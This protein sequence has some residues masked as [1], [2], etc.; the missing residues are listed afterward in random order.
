M[1]VDV[2]VRGSVAKILGLLDQGLKEES[3]FRSPFCFA[4]NAEFVRKVRTLSREACDSDAEGGPLTQTRSVPTEIGEEVKDRVIGDIANFEFQKPLPLCVENLALL[5]ADDPCFRIDNTSGVNDADLDADV[6]RSSD[7]PISL[8]RSEDAPMLIQRGVDTALDQSHEW[9]PFSQESWQALKAVV[10][11]DCE[12]LRAVLTIP[13]LLSTDLSENHTKI[14]NAVFPYRQ[15]KGTDGISVEA[16]SVEQNP[17]MFQIIC[18]ATRDICLERAAGAADVLSIQNIE[19]GPRRED[20][21]LRRLF[22]NG[23]RTSPGTDGAA[24]GEAMG[25]RRGLGREEEDCCD[26]RNSTFILRAGMRPIIANDN[27]TISRSRSWGEFHT[28]LELSLRHKNLFPRRRYLIDERHISGEN[29]KSGILSGVDD[30]EDDSSPLALLFFS[31]LTSSWQSFGLAS[32]S[33]HKNTTSLALPTETDLPWT[34]GCLGEDY[35]EIL[36]F[37][38]DSELRDVAV[39]EPGFHFRGLVNLGNTCYMNSALQCLNRVRP[40]T[41]YFL[42]NAY[43]HDLSPR[44]RF[45]SQGALAVAYNCLMRHLNSSSRSLARHQ[46]EVLEDHKD[47]MKGLKDMTENDNIGESVE[48]ADLKD[49]LARQRES[50]LGYRQQDAQEFLSVLLDSLHEDLKRPPEEGGREGRDQDGG[51]A[52]EQS[53]ADKAWTIFCEKNDSRLKDLFYG[54]FRSMVECLSCGARS[55][56]FDPFLFLSLPLPT[57]ESFVISIALFPLLT[58]IIPHSLSVVSNPFDPSL[59]ITAAAHTPALTGD[60]HTHTHTDPNDHEELFLASAS[61]SYSFRILVCIDRHLI[62]QAT[63]VSELLDRLLQCR[64]SQIFKE[65]LTLL[66]RFH[67]EAAE[68]LGTTNSSELPN[69]PCNLLYRFLCDSPTLSRAVNGSSEDPTSMSLFQ[70]CTSLGEMAFS[71]S[72]HSLLQAATPLTQPQPLTPTLTLSPME[73]GDREF[74]SLGCFLFNAPL[75]VPSSVSPPQSRPQTSSSPEEK[76]RTTPLSVPAGSLPKSLLVSLAVPSSFV[77]STSLSPVDRLIHSNSDVKNLTLF[78]FVQYQSFGKRRAP[79]ESPAKQNPPDPPHPRLTGPKLEAL[80]QWCALAA[81]EKFHSVREVD[82]ALLPFS[83]DFE[84]RLE[85]TARLAHHP[86]S[87]TRTPPFRCSLQSLVQD[88]LREPLRLV[89]LTQ[90]RPEPQAEGESRREDGIEDW[91]ETRSVC[92]Y[93]SFRLLDHALVRESFAEETTENI[94]SPKCTNFESSLVKALE[95]GAGW[96]LNTRIAEVFDPHFGDLRIFPPSSANANAKNLRICSDRIH[97]D[98][99][100]TLWATAASE[101]N[102]SQGAEANSQPWTSSVF[103]R[104]KIAGFT[105]E[106]AFE[107]RDNGG[108]ES[109]LEGSQARGEE[110]GDLLLWLSGSFPLTTFEALPSHALSFL[111]LPPDPPPKTLPRYLSKHDPKGSSSGS[112]HKADPRSDPSSDSSSEMKVNELGNHRRRAIRKGALLR[113]A[114]LLQGRIHSPLIAQCSAGPLRL[115]TLLENFTQEELLCGENA[116]F[117]EKCKMLQAAR[118]RIAI[119]R[120]PPFLIVHLG[121]FSNFG[122]RAKINTPVAFVTDKPTDLTPF[123]AEEARA[124]AQAH[125][126]T[127]APNQAQTQ[128]Q[129]QAQNQLQRDSRTALRPEDHKLDDR[130]PGLGLGQ[131]QSQS[132]SRRGCFEQRSSRNGGGYNPALLKQCD[133]HAAAAEPPKQRLKTEDSSTHTHT[134]SHTP[135]FKQ[136]GHVAAY[137]VIAFVNHTG[138]LNFG[139]YFAHVK[140]ESGNWCCLNDTLVSCLGRSPSDKDLRSESAYLLFLQREG[141]KGLEGLDAHHSPSSKPP[142]SDPPLSDHQWS[143]LHLRDPKIV[144]NSQFYKTVPPL[145]ETTSPSVSYRAKAPVDSKHVRGRDIRKHQTLLDDDLYPYLTDDDD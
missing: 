108:I 96:N 19:L 130:G 13:R 17:R 87:A 119:W 12:I 61:L 72:P 15:D 4:L 30:N 111:R 112:D 140:S 41:D 138:S 39:F 124:P 16:K 75:P 14:K 7:V 134:E 100:P 1:N 129:K 84:S 131:S 59:A 92:E 90:P 56:T 44:N 3:I 110:L 132:Q 101:G 48:A 70:S 9:L 47:D 78:V 144:S 102:G 109:L 51:D 35:S 43:R 141:F 135:T 66:R 18:A 85:R 63:T 118:K 116:W 139:H 40:L 121:R 105:A 36:V 49:I 123:I 128:A 94:P 26:W 45:S 127:E 6:L 122:L 136:D 71:V 81:V 2:N 29:R 42:S 28:R 55:K 117:C 93:R 60:T 37:F 38:E 88:I 67:R 104:R 27:F 20:A 65:I 76:T 24:T 53:E 52:G 62:A 32:R 98:F 54:Q 106:A 133:L 86:P 99:I 68:Y 22:S 115:E 58:E 57:Q 80:L 74:G 79:E 82:P 89:F 34:V 114:S 143:D 125:T 113:T 107:G 50:F 83:D 5:S 69:Q 126:H 8:A 73:I 10:I 11:V 145:P 95:T 23:V 46:A 142:A 91:R 137:R 120:L 33:S 77:S 25:G 64:E 103:D 21:L 97:I 31:T